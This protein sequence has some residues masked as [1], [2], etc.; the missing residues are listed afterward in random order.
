MSTY[1]IFMIIG[2]IVVVGGWTAYFLWDRK[3]RQE[4]EKQPKPQSQRVQKTKTDLSDW[5]KK[6]A[7]YKGPPKRPTE[8]QKTDNG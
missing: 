5:A 2:V 3:M 8:G 7:E 6:M 4:E 1:G